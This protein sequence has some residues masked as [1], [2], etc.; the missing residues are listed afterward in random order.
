MSS[1]FQHCTVSYKSDEEHCIWS[2]KSLFLGLMGQKTNISF[3]GWKGGFKG[4][5][6][7]RWIPQFWTD[8]VKKY[9]LSPIFAYKKQETRAKKEP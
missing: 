6:K 7:Q 1:S 4:L 3:N 2:E 9:F 5:I 8:K